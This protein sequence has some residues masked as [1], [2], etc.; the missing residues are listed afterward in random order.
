LKEVSPS[1]LPI[2]ELFGAPLRGEGVDERQHKR[3]IGYF[4]KKYGILKNNVA[5]AK[6]KSNF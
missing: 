4:H 3:I 2:P 6:K 1:G 5:F